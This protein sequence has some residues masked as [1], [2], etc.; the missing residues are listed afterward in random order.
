M[1][2]KKW[3]IPAY[4]LAA[5]I[6]LAIAAVGV[7]MLLSNAATKKQVEVYEVYAAMRENIGK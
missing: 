6:L 1:F 5:V 4:I 3:K 7:V 2:V